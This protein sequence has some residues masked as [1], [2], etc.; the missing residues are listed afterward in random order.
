M[1]S[2]FWATWMALVLTTLLS[3]WGLIGVKGFSFA[4]TWWGKRAQVS[5]MLQSSS[6]SNHS[7]VRKASS[8][9]AGNDSNN[10]RNMSMD[11]LDIWAQRKQTMYDSKRTESKSSSSTF[12][13][14]IYCNSIDSECRDRSRI[15]STCLLETEMVFIFEKSSSSSS[16]LSCNGKTFGKQQCMT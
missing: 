7:R 1:T 2:I 4:F 9:F 8:V 5:V 16:P 6:D 11:D 10:C 3:F 13:I 14:L 12:D 15:D